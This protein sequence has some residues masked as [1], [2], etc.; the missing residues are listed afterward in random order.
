MGGG[1]SLVTS[2]LLLVTGNRQPATK[3][4]TENEFIKLNKDR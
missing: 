1:E 3:Q 2:L 4:V